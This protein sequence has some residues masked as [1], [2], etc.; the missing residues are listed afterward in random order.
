MSVSTVSMDNHDAAWVV[1][2]SAVRSGRVDV[3]E[4]DRGSEI[5][6]SSPHNDSRM[7]TRSPVVMSDWSLLHCCAKERPLNGRRRRSTNLFT[8]TISSLMHCKYLS[9]ESDEDPPL[10][11]KIFFQYLCA[12]KVT[13]VERNSKIP[14]M[15][16]AASSTISSHP[17][18]ELVNVSCCKL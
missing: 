7:G 16:I 9:H 12:S 13:A 8:T 11:A 14:T 4:D 15:R 1:V 18:L 5:H 6:T 2:Q 10:C 3:A 17:R